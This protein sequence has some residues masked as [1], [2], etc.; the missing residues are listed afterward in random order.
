MS[1]GDDGPWYRPS[2]AA[3]LIGRSAR[4]VRDLCHDKQ[5]D[6]REDVG[7]AGAVR[8]LVSRQAIERYKQRTIVRA[9]V[10]GAA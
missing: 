5:I 8:Y 2:E 6:H 3:P 9:Q 1:V 10:R 4:F 7:P